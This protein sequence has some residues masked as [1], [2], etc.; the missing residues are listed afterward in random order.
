MKTKKTWIIAALVM[1]FSVASICSAAS[2]TFQ[3]PLKA[4]TVA[5]VLQSIMGYLKGI[6]GT[7][8]VIFIIIGGIMYMLSAGNKEM[9]ERGKKTLLY[10]I[11]G[12]AIVLAAP[13]F[14]K[15][16]MTII[17]GSA[18]GIG[19]LSLQQ[20]AL[21]V[22]R[23]LLSIV[24]ML[25]IIGIIIGASWMLTAAGD[26]DR[27]ELGKNTVTYAIVGIAIAVGALI[28]VQTIQSIVGGKF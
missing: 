25:A 14:L 22:L 24:G 28:I 19:G 13:T 5:Q 27:Y 21:N 7:I 6:A 26:K 2:V 3:N 9:M 18:P 8:A 12:A 23:L 4:N 11:A 16:I 15:E 1:A 17:G 10:A 20:I